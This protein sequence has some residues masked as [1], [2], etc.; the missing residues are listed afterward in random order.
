MMMMNEEDQTYRTVQPGWMDP[1]FSRSDERTNR[2]VVFQYRTQ[3]PLIL[4]IAY[5]EM[6]HHRSQNPILSY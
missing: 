2:T 5:L 6:N 3:V 1:C 4:L